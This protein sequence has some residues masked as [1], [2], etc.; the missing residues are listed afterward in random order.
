MIKTAFE[1]EKRITDSLKE[2]EKRKVQKFIL[3]EGNSFTMGTANGSENEQPPHL[4]NLNSYLIEPTEVTNIQY[5]TFLNEYNSIFIKSGDYEG[6][7][8]IL[9]EGNYKNEKCRIYKSGSIYKVESGYDNFPVIYVS[10]YG[11]NEYCKHFKMKLPTEAEWEFAAKGGNVSKNYNFSGSN[12]PEDVSWYAKNANGKVHEV[13]QKQPNELGLYD[14]TGN[15]WEWCS[16][17][18]STYSAAEQIN[19]QGPPNG[20]KK[21]VRGGA[22]YLGTDL[23]RNTNRYAMEV[24]HKGSYLG[25]RCACGK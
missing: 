3:I 24:E 20:N 8:L 22:W 9:L 1:N 12:N 17:W 25:F 15:V 18:Y 11:A 2:I 16:D 23:L 5:A 14:M 19:P 13:K 6:K 4:I 7:L 21:V 10:W